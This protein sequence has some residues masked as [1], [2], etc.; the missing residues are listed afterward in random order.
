MTTIILKDAKSFLDGRDLS[1][2]LSQINLNMT[3]DMKE[4]SVFGDDTVRNTPA[5]KSYDINQ[6]GFWD[7]NA[8][9]DIIANID[10]MTKTMLL[11]L[12][13]EGGALGDNAFIG[14]ARVSNYTPGAAHGELFEFSFDLVPEGTDLIRGKVME[15]VNA[16]LTTSTLGTIREFTGGVSAT[17]KLVCQLHVV[18][19]SGTAP[20]LDVVI[21]SDDAVGF[22][23]PLPRLTFTQATG[24]TAERKE[25]VGP[26]TDTF[27]R[28]N[29]TIAGG[30]P[31]FTV[32]I[33]LAIVE[34]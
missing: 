25:L 9:A 18:A 4:S 16:P 5:L 32:F 29:L 14:V 10:D 7:V 24:R 33:V 12:T 1:G 3:R 17:Q 26:L 11:A 28:A 21:E 13:A 6:S 31:S 30:T 27:F 15:N 19:A 34:K 22:A 20:L 23:T 8:D 2:V